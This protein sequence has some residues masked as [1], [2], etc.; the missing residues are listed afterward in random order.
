MTYSL[1]AVIMGSASKRSDMSLSDLQKIKEMFK[2]T[3][4]L[5]PHISEKAGLVHMLSW[6]LM[7]SQICEP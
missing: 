2:I 1:V 7:G 6:P 3:H 4:I 5:S